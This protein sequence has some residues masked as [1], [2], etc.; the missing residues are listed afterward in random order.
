MTMGAEQDA[1]AD[2]PAGPKSAR[3]TYFIP[4]E[5][6]ERVRD[7]AWWDRESVNSLVIDGLERMLA[8]RECKRG[9]K[10]PKRERPL[11]RSGH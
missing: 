5:L 8:D 10:Y 4:T 6:A 9:S 3:V 11:R 2:Q 7:V 1:S